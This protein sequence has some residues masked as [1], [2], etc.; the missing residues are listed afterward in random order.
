M[1]KKV[2]ITG[3]VHDKDEL[4]FLA[5]QARK[6]STVRVIDLQ[7]LGN[8]TTLPKAM[9]SYLSQSFVTKGL[10]D[11]VNKLAQQARDYLAGTA[12]NLE[13]GYL[14]PPD[15]AVATA[16]RFEDIK[17]QYEAAVATLLD[18]YNDALDKAETELRNQFPGYEGM[19]TL[20]KAI[21]R[22]APTHEYLEQ[23]LGFDFQMFTV[24]RVK[25]DYDPKSDRL[26]SSG[27]LSLHGGLFGRLVV[28]ICGIA[29][30]LNR[31]LADGDV[32][33]D[34]RIKKKTFDRVHDIVGKIELMNFIDPK[35][36]GDM[37]QLITSALSS[38]PTTFPLDQGYHGPFCE[39]VRRLSNQSHVLNCLDKGLP[40]F[41][42]RAPVSVPA[43]PAADPVP[44]VEVVNADPQPTSTTAPEVAALFSF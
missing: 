38:F 5:F 15:Q 6:F 29:G 43:Q 40:L 8:V 3:K 4:I 13:L 27:F 10:L 42:L 23:N 18:S 31:E 11:E 25:G 16:E 19:D 9:R 39:L 22:Q 37:K 14:L 2:T 17:A 36:V 32:A 30:V 1:S 21:R 26:V 41:E 7:Q 34:G 28:D 33:S 12:L 24:G 44:E 20:V 35:K